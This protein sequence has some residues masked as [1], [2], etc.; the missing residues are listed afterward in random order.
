M[1]AVL[2]TEHQH[3]VPSRV[4]IAIG[5]KPEIAGV[6]VT[7]VYPAALG[8][9]RVP[10]GLPLVE[11]GVRLLP[12]THRDPGSGDRCEASFVYRSNDCG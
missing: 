2:L 1:D 7:R 5:G 10:I 8:L 4:H 11:V 12:A 9:E 6:D 3:G